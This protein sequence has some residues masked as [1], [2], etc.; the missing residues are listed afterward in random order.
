VAALRR[1]GIEAIQVSGDERKNKT[2]P[3]TQLLAGKRLVYTTPEFLLLNA[4]MRAWLRKAGDEARL[5]RIVLDEAHC[6]L[7]W[8]NT[9]RP[10]YL[11]LSRWKTQLFSEVPVTL[12]TA[13]VSDE[14]IAKLAELF[15]VELLQ[16]IPAEEEKLVGTEARHGQMVL[17]QQ[18]TDRKNLRMEV[19][20]KTSTSAHWIAD[21]VGDATAIVFCMTRRDADDTCLAL[22]R[23]G[24]RAGVYHG[25]LPRK[26]REFVRKQWM[27]G[28]LTTICATSAFGV[29]GDLSALPSCL[30]SC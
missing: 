16:W 24:C 23:V 29:S 26:R 10:S 8:G 19:V 11:E 5:A 12:A 2:V 4:E 15:H 17:V 7:E 30:I 28:Q 20:R 13:S 9:F 22:V 1:K 14:D 27:M 6:V 25:G 21:R 3:L 18:V